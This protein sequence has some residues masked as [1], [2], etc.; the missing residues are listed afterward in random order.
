MAVVLKLLVVADFGDFYF[1]DP[2]TDTLAFQTP[3][4]AGNARPGTLLLS[5]DGRNEMWDGMVAE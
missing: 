4:F 2:G 5:T 3:P 1:R